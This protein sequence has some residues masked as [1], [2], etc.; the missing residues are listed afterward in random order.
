MRISREKLEYIIKECIRVRITSML[1]ESDGVRPVTLDELYEW[2]DEFNEKY[3]NNS[4]PKVVIKLEPIGNTIWG[5]F[6]GYYTY[7]TNVYGRQEN[8]RLVLDRCWITINSSYN[9]TEYNI[10][11]TLLH[12]MVHLK[13][14]YT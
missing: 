14:G 13:I 8:R 2:F 12:E 5:L 7:R 10:R 4:L 6:H 3:F 1:F 11:N 9:G